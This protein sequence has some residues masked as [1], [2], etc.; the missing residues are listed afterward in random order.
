MKHWYKKKPE[1]LFEQFDGSNEMIDKYGLSRII[2]LDGEFTDTFYFEDR[3][4]LTIGDWIAT[5][6]NGEHWSVKDEIFKKTFWSFGQLIGKTN[7]TYYLR[8]N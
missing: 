8:I 3:M 5:V 7:E 2:A 4:K 1:I 6:T